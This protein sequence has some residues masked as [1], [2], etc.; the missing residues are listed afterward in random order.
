MNKKYNE[1][2]ISSGGIKGFSI[3]GALQE[4]F[5]YYPIHNIK[6][7]TGTSVGAL[8]CTLLNI[9]YNLKELEEI[10]LH[11]DF[12]LFQ[13]LKVMNL[14]ENCGF[15]NGIKF[16]NLL[17][18]LFMSK[19]FN[20]NITFKELYYLT[21]K[22]LTIVVT[23]ITKGII[24]YHNYITTPNLNILLSLRMST[25]VPLLFY[26]IIYNNNYYLDG[27]L[28]DPF[29]YFYHKNTVKVGLW[30]HQNDEF[31]FIHN[32]EMY[33]VNNTNNVISYTI[34]LLRIIYANYIKKYYKK[35]P[36]DIIHIDY[37]QDTIDFTLDA[38][39]K[40]KLIMIGR[41][42]CKIYLNKL[43]KKNRKRYL[44]MKYYFLWKNKILNKKKNIL[45]FVYES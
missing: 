40:N 27:A 33:F 16:N 25:N 5:D 22:F 14:I 11:V 17:K 26:P 42:K 12:T 28:L 6:Y 23:N 1:L 32:F 9:N 2:V 38:P 30:I 45:D 31:N 21:N 43:Y 36:K 34:N 39:Q 18:A 35:L 10:I 19:N 37:D 15:D 41:K 29:P 20:H 13:E 4:F 24:E 7:Y 3:V 8:I 44:S